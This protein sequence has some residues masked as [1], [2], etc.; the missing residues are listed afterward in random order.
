[1]LIALISPNS[2]SHWAMKRAW[3]PREP[4][5]T[6]YM[7]NAYHHIIMEIAKQLHGNLHCLDATDLKLSLYDQQP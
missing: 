7:S 3:I 4:S 5:F 1:M 6:E 2:M